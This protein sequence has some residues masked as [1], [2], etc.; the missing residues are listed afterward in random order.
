[1][2]AVNT[3]PIATP[4]KSDT[5]FMTFPSTVLSRPCGHSVHS[6]VCGLAE[7]RHLF[8]NA[9]HRRLKPLPDQEPAPLVL[10]QLELLDGYGLGP[11]AIRRFDSAD[12]FAF[13][14]HDDD[15]PASELGRL[16]ERDT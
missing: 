14:A 4:A 13:A 9:R 2:P 5:L 16:F 3:A 11:L 10:V 1:M 15:A 8:A 12:M 7:K 6:S